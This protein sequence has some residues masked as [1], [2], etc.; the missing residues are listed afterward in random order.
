[1]TVVIITHNTAIAPMADKVIKFKN[2]ISHESLS[3]QIS[4]KTCKRYYKAI[5]IGTIAPDISKHIN[6]TK[7]KSHFL[8]NVEDNIPNIDKFLAKYKNNYTRRKRSR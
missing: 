5:L 4:E 7:L 3:K 1:M 6:E 8:D 2:D